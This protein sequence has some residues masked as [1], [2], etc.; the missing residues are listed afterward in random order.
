MVKINNPLVSVVVPVMNMER[1]IDSTLRSLL[2]QT[3]E[4]REIIVVD[5]GSTDRTKDI[6][7]KHSVKLIESEGKGLSYDRNLG[8]QNSR[9]KIVAFIDADC[10][11]DKDWLKYLIQNYTFDSI[12]GCGGEI[13]PYSTPYVDY[14]P[15]TL[16]ERFA[17]KKHIHPRYYFKTEKPVELKRVENDF[18]SGCIMTANASYRKDILTK[19][20]GFDNTLS[21]SGEDI[22]LCY[23][24]HDMGLKIIWDPRA[25]VYHRHRRT[26]N[27]LI[28]QFYKYGKSIAPVN[29][30]YSS[31]KVFI[32]FKHYTR[33]FEHTFSFLKRATTVYSEKDK[34][35]YLFSPVMSSLMH[36]S[37]IAGKIRGSTKNGIFTF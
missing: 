19:V 34:E 1:T 10:V 31:K 14:V 3:Y 4:N 15:Q 21:E 26:I 12:A 8:I 6:V 9:G 29:K 33:L 25:I 30:K 16:V 23:K 27:G 24:I 36:L 28:K 35:L 22:D 2:L 37:L 20:E 17:C 13:L 5:G 18:L 7:K 11:A 32:D